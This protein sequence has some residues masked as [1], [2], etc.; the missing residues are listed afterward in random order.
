MQYREGGGRHRDNASCDFQESSQGVF[1]NGCP[2]LFLSVGGNE[3]GFLS[4]R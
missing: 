3:E 1:P 4:V 2:V